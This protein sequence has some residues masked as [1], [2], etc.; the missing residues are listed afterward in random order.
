MSKVV[1]FLGSPR[2]NGHSTKLVEQALA[3]AK[4]VGAEVVI[5]DL[6]EEGVKGCQGCLYCLEHDG[7]ATN[8]KLQPMYKDIAEADGIVVSFPIY[9][10]AINGQSKQWLDRML[11]MIG[12][13][14][15]ARYPGK[16][17]VTVFS[18]ANSHKFLTKSTIRKTNMYFKTFKWKLVDSL[19]S[20]GS[21]YGSK[22]ANYTIPQKLLDR[23]FEAGKKLIS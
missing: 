22:D 19:L 21:G 7:C 14:F 6:N 10:G 2:K 1:A 18:Q 20:Y 4:S 3:G 15:K 8:D 17:I 12:G 5:Y 16:K 13:D 9:F 11:P 23:S